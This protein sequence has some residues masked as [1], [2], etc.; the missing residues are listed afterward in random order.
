MTVSCPHPTDDLCQFA[1]KLV[2]SFSQYHVNKSGY[3]RT[4]KQ[5]SR[6]HYA[7]H[8]LDWHGHNNWCQSVH[9]KVKKVKEVYLY[10]AF[11]VVPHTQG[12]QVR[13]TQCYL[14]ITPYLPL[15]RKHSPHGASLDSGWGHLLA[16]YSFICPKRM[17]GCRPGWL[18]YSGWF[19]HISGHLSAAGRVQDSES[20]P[21]RDRRSTTVPRNQIHVGCDNE[22]YHHDLLVQIAIKYHYFIIIFHD[23]KQKIKQTSAS[24]KLTQTRHSHSK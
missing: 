6:K 7:P 21:V 12:A 2:H 24:V 10:S 4:K 14:Q 11:I 16:A 19:T 3:G 23:N 17:K 8:S 22:M 5:T 15:P 18:T 9:V 1:A 20:S 13:I